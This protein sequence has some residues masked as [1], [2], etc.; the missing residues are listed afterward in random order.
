[1]ITALETCDDGNRVSGDGCSSACFLEP[2][3]D[4]S[5]NGGAGGVSSDNACAPV[6]GDGFAEAPE[7]C[8]LGRGLNDDSYGGCRRDCRFAPYCGDGVVD[9]EEECDDGLNQTGYARQ[10]ESGCGF[11]C[12]L[13]GYC[14]DGLIDVFHGE[15]CDD[16]A[17]NGH[18][19]CLADCSINPRW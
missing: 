5:G 4:D 14:G 2:Q 18:G 12:R 3:C 8:D 10:Q 13:P 7:E 6:C 11:G 17:L 1:V 16:G 9:P 15:A 19:S